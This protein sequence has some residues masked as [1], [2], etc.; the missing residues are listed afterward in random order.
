MY[1]NAL[2]RTHPLIF[3]HVREYG[4]AAMQAYQVYNESSYLST[5]VEIWEFAN[6]YTLTAEQVAH[7]ETDVKEF[8]IGDC[9]PSELIR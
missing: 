7:K 3:D 4:Y 5:A 2:V 9:T 1:A 6:K 8:S